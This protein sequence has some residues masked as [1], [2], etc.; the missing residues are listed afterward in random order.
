MKTKKEERIAIIQNILKINK[1]C[2]CRECERLE[3]ELLE[4]L[5]NEN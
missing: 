4:L 3:K 2:G 1:D 5:Q